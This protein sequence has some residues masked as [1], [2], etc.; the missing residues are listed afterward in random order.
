MGGP[1]GETKVRFLVGDRSV[2]YT[3]VGVGLV[4]D[5][6]KC[7]LVGVWFDW[8]QRARGVHVIQILFG[9][10]SQS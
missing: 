9:T 3:V 10:S 1:R 2:W 5:C 6:R 7:I 8:Y 4:E